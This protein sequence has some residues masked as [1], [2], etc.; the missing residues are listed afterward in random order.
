MKKLSFLLILVLLACVGN[1]L[2]AQL[3]LT[4]ANFDIR[5]GDTLR[6]QWAEFPAAVQVPAHGSGQTYDLS[7]ASDIPFRYNNGA[8]PVPAG[9]PQYSTATFANPF[10][11]NFGGLIAQTGYD[12]Y[13]VNTNQYVRLGRYFNPAS[14]GFTATD[15]I[16]FP[17][18]DVVFSGQ[19][20]ILKFPL[21]L[22]STLNNTYRSVVNFTL[23]LPSFGLASGAGQLAQVVT[24]TD[25]VVGSGNLTLPGGA[26]LPVLLYKYH[27]VQVD[28]YYVD[29]AP[30]PPQLLSGFGL[31]QGATFVSQY[32]LM[33]AQGFEGEVA[34]INYAGRDTIREFRYLTSAAVT[35]VNEQLDATIGL[36]MGPNPLN[37]GQS[38]NLSFDKADGA[39]WGLRLMDPLGRQTDLLP[40]SAPAGRAAFSVA[41]GTD[42]AG[43]LYFV[44][45]TDGA[46]NVRATQRL[47]V[48]R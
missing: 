19:D 9:F 34:F 41:L 13:E 31:T 46:G 7:G 22:G 8:G 24:T 6:Y 27:A 16:L 28:S 35:S 20:I 15:S 44:T 38:L 3:T 29:G 17:A 45:L 1:C 18:Q 26:T 47:L 37:V 4:S 10:S 30:A 43:G 12:F 11:Q 25:T 23:K 2:H 32:Y 40:L 33:Y 42:L 36:S 39:D 14:A 21:A 5:P 48:V